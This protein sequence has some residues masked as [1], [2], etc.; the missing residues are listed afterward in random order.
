MTR[1]RGANL[2]ILGA[3]LAVALS[4][5]P[6]RTSAADQLPAGRQLSAPTASSPRLAVPPP[7][8][9][10]VLIRTT[11][12]ALNQAVQTGNFTVLR[13]L[14]SPALQAAN[15]ATQLGIIFADLRNKEIDLSPTVVVTP[16]LSE[17]PVI[18]QENM[19]RLVGSFPTTPL[20][21]KFQMLFQ[22]VD[23]QWRLLAMA[24]HCVSAPKVSARDQ[25]TVPETIAS[26]LASTHTSATSPAAKGISEWPKRR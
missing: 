9:L 7:E 24:A 4:L 6:S 2:C 21:I 8:V 22:P 18:T 16:Q 17:A 11:L 25:V 1:A 15:S 14:G 5:L 19:L 20:E 12:V 3:A 23:G 10:L 13:D 26:N